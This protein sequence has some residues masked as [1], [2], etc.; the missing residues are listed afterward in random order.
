MICETFKGQWRIQEFRKGA[1]AKLVD[2]V[3][4]GDRFGKGAVPSTQ[5]RNFLKLLLKMA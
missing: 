3:G 1:V 4:L 2:I 5:V